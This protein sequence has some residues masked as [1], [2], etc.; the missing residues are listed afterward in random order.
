[1]VSA[2]VSSGVMVRTSRA[3]VRVAEDR[4]QGGTRK[5]LPCRGDAGAVAAAAGGD[6]GGGA[7]RGVLA[8]PRPMVRPTIMIWSGR[9]P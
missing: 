9:T 3:V 6:D 8:S 1:M 4:L 7:A 2:Y 5:S